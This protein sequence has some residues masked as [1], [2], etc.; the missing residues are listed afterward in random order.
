MEKPADTIPAPGAAAP[1]LPTESPKP[2]APVMDV[3]APPPAEKPADDTL[4]VAPVDSIEDK[5][6]DKNP[7]MPKAPKQPG[8]GVGLA[9][10]ATVIIVI[11]LAAL[12]TFAF[13]QTK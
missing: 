13:V 2:A 4:V 3:V 5:H 8:N 11:A 9:I 1:P 12:A 7:P 10:T 6:P